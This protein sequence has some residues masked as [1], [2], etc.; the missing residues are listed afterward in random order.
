MRVD[1]LT[2]EYPPHVYGG[3]GVHV[4]ELARVLAKSI[5]VRVH[6]FDGPRLNGDTEHDV[7]VPVTGYDELPELEQANAAAADVRRRPRDRRQPR[8]DGPRPLPHL[9]RQP[10]RHARLAAQRRPA[11]A[12]RP[13]PGAAA[14]VEG[15]AARRRVRPVEL[16]RAHRLRAG[17]GRHRRLRRHARGHP[18]RLPAGG[19]GQGA[20]RPQRHRPRPGGTARDSDAE[21][22][23]GRGHAGP[24][25][26][27]ARPAHGRLRRAHHPAEGPAVPAARR[28]AAARGGPARAVRRRAG[29]QGDRRGGHRAGR[30]PPGPPRR[31]GVDRGDAARGPS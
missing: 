11:R 1:M 14:P 3:A 10:R 24:A 22:R 28:R 5:D 6:A 29:H 20:R 16:G 12:L 7:E 27:R 4:T 26:R 31:G 21:L 13:L 18:A 2:R 19:P 30:G 17:G 9:V 23:G 15:R 8:R 25:R